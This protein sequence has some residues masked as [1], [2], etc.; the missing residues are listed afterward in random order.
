[1][2]PPWPTLE[3]SGASRWG[4]PQILEEFPPLVSRD[5]PILV[6]APHRG[7]IFLAKSAKDL[8][9]IPSRLCEAEDGAGDGKVGV[10][11]AGNG[12][13]NLFFTRSFTAVLPA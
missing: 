10:K 1:M 12:G 13:G 3:G 8:H 4:Q 7:D 9:S 11:T 2:H 6:L 5:R